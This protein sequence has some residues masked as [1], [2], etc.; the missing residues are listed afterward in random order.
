MTE[1]T[2]DVIVIGAGPV[3]QTRAERTRAAGLTVAVIE[4]ELV[5]GE[6]SYWGCVPSKALLRPV[7]AVADADRVDGARE[8]VTGPVDATAVFRR[9][10]R[11]VSD[12]DD[13]G[14]AD[15]VRGIGADLFRGHGRLDGRRRVTVTAADGEVIALTARQA[16]AVCIGSTAALPD[17]PGVAEANPWTNRGGTESSTVP[18]RLA[19]VGGGG[20]AVELATAWQGLGSSVTLLVR[21]SSVLTRMEPFVGEYVARGLRD[22]G[23]DVRLGV[24]VKEVQRPGGDGPIIV[25]L[26]DGSDLEVEEILFAT[27]RAPLTGEVGLD[28]VGLA[29][30]SWLDTDDTLRVRGV[31]GDWLYAV[32]DA[33]HR[34]LLTHQG[35]YQARVAAAAI[36]ARAAGG[37]VDMSAWSPFVATADTVAVPQAFFTDPEAGSV[38]L[39]AQQAADTGLRTRVV[40]IAIGEVVTGAKLYADGYPGQARMVVDEDHGHLLGVTMVGPGVAEMLHSATV[41]VAGQ[42]PVDRLW[43]AVPCFPTVSELWLRM[44]E[45]YRDSGAP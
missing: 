32:G 34:A 39:T 28:T 29:P 37:D 25:R 30:G 15:W 1:P 38:G 18:A 35:K 27:G 33:N 19:V 31:E 41:A 20:V 44:L 10:D 23:V 40:D 26:D 14:Q 4:R 24:S 36:V 42:V 22:A 43:H 7:L 21:G 17:T 8:A 5:G 9:R 12:W 16:V 13:S 11:Y 6:C 2:Y 45:A 3:G